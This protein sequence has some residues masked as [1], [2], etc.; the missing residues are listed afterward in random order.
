MTRTCR[1]RKKHARS[2]PPPARRVGAGGKNV[3][4]EANRLSYRN[5]WADGQKYGRAQMR[6]LIRRRLR[7]MATFEERSEYRKL[8]RLAADIT[9]QPSREER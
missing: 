8:L 1:K 7:R 9:T 2:D 4:D 3:S 6:R 5:G